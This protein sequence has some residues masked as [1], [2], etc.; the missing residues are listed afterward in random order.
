MRYAQYLK[1]EG[2][3][4]A[5]DSGGILERW[6]YG[7]RLLCDDTAMAKSGKSLKHGVLERL[8]A[9][10]KAKG[11]RLSEREIQ[12]RLACGR[13]YPTEAQIRQMLADFDTWDDLHSAGFPAVERS[14]DEPDYDPR[15]SDERARDV[16]NQGARLLPEQDDEEQLALFPDDRFHDLSTLAEMAKYAEEMAEITARFAERDAERSAYMRRLIDAVDGDM[17]TTWAEARQALG[18]QGGT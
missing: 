5:A 11:Y 16:Q 6:R 12:R 4:S 1:A 10:A 8:I 2:H 7:R 17:S 13:A 18:A 3:I 15:W 9:H 14:P